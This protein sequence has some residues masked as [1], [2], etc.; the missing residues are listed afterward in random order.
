ML[1]DHISKRQAKYVDSRLL[2]HP[3]RSV[4]DIAKSLLSDLVSFVQEMLDFMEELYTSC[5]DSFNALT[6]AWELV[7]HC[8]EELFTKEFK[9]SLQHCLAQDLVDSR[10]TLTGVLHTAFSLNVKVR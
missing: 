2:T 6:K 3:D 10:E 8:L 5:N 9:P 7:C 4:Y 1:L